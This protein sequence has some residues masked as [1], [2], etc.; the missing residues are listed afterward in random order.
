MRHFIVWAVVL[1]LFNSTTTA[2]GIPF[3]LWYFFPRE[4]TNLALQVVISV[5]IGN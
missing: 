3:Y 5:R 4:E 1:A 2:V